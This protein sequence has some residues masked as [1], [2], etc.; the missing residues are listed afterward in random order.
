MRT[1]RSPPNPPESLVG[2]QG[3]EP[4]TLGL[5]ARRPARKSAET[6][7]AYARAPRKRGAG[8]GPVARSN[9]T[10]T[11]PHRAP[12]GAGAPSGCLSTV[13]SGSPPGTTQAGP[14]SLPSGDPRACRLPRRAR[15]PCPPLA[16]AEAPFPAAAQRRRQA[17]RPSRRVITSRPVLGSGK[18]LLR[19]KS[20]SIG[21]KKTR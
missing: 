20:G 8:W 13:P 4:W 10:V 21:P 5:K 14:G 7:R 1:G 17:A 9:P 6:A 16:E 18:C 19:N 3:L 2:R 11:P 12:P 15:G